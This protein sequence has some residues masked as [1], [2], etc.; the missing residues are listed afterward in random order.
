M[1]PLS[2]AQRRLWFIDRLE[3][4]SATYN[5]P[6]RIRFDGGLDVEALRSALN[7]VVARH[8]SLR[9]LVTLDD[10]GVPWQRVL[11]AEEAE[12]DLPVVEI[13]GGELDA[14]VAEA[15]R[16]VLDVEAGIP[17]RATLFRCGP[18]RHVLLLLIHHIASD[19]ESLAPLSRDLSTAYTA[20][21]RGAAPG[22]AELPVQYADYTLWQRELLGDEADP[23]SVFSTQS[24]YWQAELAGL[25]Q[26]I[27]LPLDRPRPASA[28]HRG[29]VISARLE[30]ELVAAIGALARE[31]GCTPPML[32]QAALAVL[33]QHLG[34]G[35]DVAVGSTIAG[36]TDDQLG[37]LIGFFVNSWVLRVDLSGSPS[38]G[39]VLARVKEKALGAYD[40]QDIPF[41]RL[42]ELVNPVR[43]TAWHP[44]FQVMFTWGD[45]LGLD[46]DLPS[47]AARIDALPTP[48]AKFDLEVNFFSDPDGHGL[49][50]AL[51]YAT[52]LFDRATAARVIE[53][54]LRVI[55]Q[56]IDAPDL[57]VAL[58]DPL[59]EQERAGLLEAARG[60]VSELPR[61]YVPAIVDEQARAHPD[62]VAVLCDGLSLTYAELCWRADRVASALARRGAG[63]EMLVGLALPR[64]ADLVVGL[65]GILKCGAAYLPV[66]P[67]YP[68][69]RLDAV[70]AEARPAAILADRSTASALPTTESPIVLI[71]EDIDFDGDESGAAGPAVRGA[72]P[73]NIAYVMYTSGS[74][75]K[76]KGVAITHAGVV[77]GV[78]ALA[79][80][81]G[82]ESRSSILAATSIG[83]DVSV[84]EIVTPLLAGGS[85]EIVRDGLVIGERGGWSGGVVSTVPSV[86]AGVLDGIA[87]ELKADT[88]VFA[89]EVLPMS[90]A[91]RVRAALPGV[92][93]INAYG[94]TESFYATAFQLPAELSDGASAPIG[95]P[96]ANMRCYVLGPGLQPVPAG[97]V[98]EL[99]VAGAVG[100]GY[101]GRSELTAARFVADPFG[102]PGARMYRTGDLVRS[103]RDGVLE[104]VGRDDAQVK[105]RGVRV[106]T[107]EV[108]AALAAFPG[109][110]QAV[111]VASGEGPG[112]RLVG[113]V[114]PN[115]AEQ[116]AGDVDSLG[117]LTVDLT[118]LLSA[119][120]L[121]R[122]VAGRLPE[123][124][125]PSAFVVLDRVPLMSNG[126]LDRAALPEPEFRGGEYRAPA[127]RTEEVLASLYAD[128]LG[129]ERAG[130]DDDFFA[131]GGDSIRSIQVVS[132]AKGVGVEITPRDVFDCRTPA[133]L[134]RRTADRGP[135][136]NASVLNELEGGGIGWMPLLPVARYVLDLGGDSDRFAMAMAVDLPADIDEDGLSAT[137]ASVFECHDA[138]RSRLVAD[139]LVVSAP[140][141]VPAAPLV[142][143]IGWDHG[144]GQDWHDLAAAELDAAARRL[145]PAAGTMAQFVWFAPS[146]AAGRLLIVVHH[147][148]VDGVSWRVLL[149]DLASAWQQVRDGAPPVLLPARTSMRRWAHAIA[150]EAVSERRAAELPMWREILDTED[151]VLGARR[152][153]PAE[154]T[155]STMAHRW[156][157]LS[158]RTTEAVLTTL[159]ARYRSGAHDGL[160]AALAMA[161]IRWRRARGTGGSAVLVR[162]EGHGREEGAIPGAD[163]SRT[164]GW[165]TTTYPVGLDLSGIDLGGAFAGSDP[166][167][168]VVKAVK[169][170]LVAVP[171]RGIGFGLL[172]YLNPGTA[173]VLRNCPVPQIAFNYLGRY[174]SADLPE[175][176][177][178]LGWSQAPG[179]AGL[180]P[181]PDPDMCAPAVLDLHALVEDT[182]DGP[183]L[184]IRIGYAKNIL[185]EDETREL[186]ELFEAALAGLARHADSPGAGGLTPSDLPLVS[187]GQDAIAAWE[188]RYPGLRDAWPLTPMQAGLLFHAELAGAGF[189]S[190][191]M[192]LVLH[193][194]GPV[195]P[196]RLRRAGQ[197]LL[198]RYPNLRVA[199]PADTGGNRVQVVQD[200]VELPWRH[201]DFA[202]VKRAE[203]QDRLDR[204]LAEDRARHFGL[205]EAPLLR[206]SLVTLGEGR[207]DLVFTAHHVLLDGW[208]VPLLMEDLLR[209]YAT[210]GDRSGLPATRSYRDF[211]EWLAVQDHAAAREAWSAE[212]AGL[213]EPTLLL[214]EPSGERPPSGIGQVEVQLGRHE[215]RALARLG[216]VSGLT[217]NTLVQGA[218][219]LVLSFLTGRR[220]V[221]FGAA[222]SG[223]PP[224]VPGIDGMVGLFVTTLPIRVDCDPASTLR[225]LLTSLQRRQSALL[226]HHHR[227]LQDIQ[228]ESGLTALF[229]TLVGFESYP[230]DTA[231]LSAAGAAAG[232]EITGASPFSGAHY[233]LAVMAFA[234][235]YLRIALQY[236]HH[237][238]DRDAAE[239][240]AARLGRALRHLLADLDTLV[241]A[242][243]LAEP[244]E[245]DVVLERFNRTDVA[246]VTQTIP[247][248]IAAL[249][250]TQPDSVAVVCGDTVLSYRDLDSRAARLA[251]VLA[252]RGVDREAVVG[253][254]L[255]RS[256]DL[257]VA[258]AALLRAGGAY[259]PIDPEYP[260]ERMAFMLRDTRPALV[261]TT[262]ELADRFGAVGGPVLVLDDPGTAAEVESASPSA[263]LPGHADQL[264]YVMY[265][266]GSSGVPKGIAVPHRAV[267]GLADD[268]RYRGGDHQ[269]VL[270]HS[271]Q[272]FDAST[273]DL[274]VALLGGGRVVVAPPGRL[275][276]AA[277]AGLLAEEEITGL[278]LPT[279]LFRVVAEE[280]P[281]CLAG[282]REV[283][284]GG[285][286][287]P[288]AAIARVLRSCP[289]ISVVNGYGPTETTTFA[290]CYPMRSPEEIGDPVPIGRPMDGMRA[291]VL[292]AALRPA[293]PG[294]TGDLYL[295]GNGLARGYA[296]RR[297]L[298]AE[299]FVA[300]PFGGP[301]GRMYRTGDRVAWTAE[302]E[303]DYR[304]RADEQV[305][306]RGF[307][308]EPG[309]VEAAM[310]TRRGVAEAVVSW[311]RD[312]GGERRLVGYVVPELDGTDS[313]GGADPVDEWR[314]LYND[315]YAGSNAAFGEDFKGWNSSYDG[316]PIA[317]P[318]MAE[319]RDA[320]VGAILGW[321]PRRILEIGVGT[322]LLLARLVSEVEEFWGTDIS[323]PVIDRLTRQVERAGY[324]DRVRLRAGAADE[325]GGL[326]AARFDTVVL[327]SVVQYFPDT[328]YLDRV[329]SDAMG[330]LAPGGRIVVGDVRS[331]ASL[332]L[333]HA[334]VRRARHPGEPAAAAR[335]SIE[336]AMLMEEELAL[337]PEWFHRWAA[338]HGAVADIR[339]KRGRAHNELT[340]HRYEVT[341]HRAPHE[342]VDLAEAPV[343]RW[344]RHVGRLS[345]AE[346]WTG[347]GPVRIAGIPN[348]RLSGEAAAAGRSAPGP[349]LDPEDAASWA[350][351][352]GLGVILAPSADPR[353]FDAIIGFGLAARGQVL[354]GAFVPAGRAARAWASSPARARRIGVLVG[355]LHE[356]LRDQ[357]PGYLVPEAVIAIARVPLTANNK[358][359]RT[360]LPAPDFAGQASGRG[361]RGPREQILCGLCAEVLG[362]DRIGIDDDFFALGG[363][364]LSAT[365]LISRIRTT[366][367][368]EVPIS[369]VFESPT[370]A[371]LSSR[372]APGAP[373]R[374][375]LRPAGRR[376]EPVPMSYA[377]RRM[378]FIDRFEGPSA[379]YNAPVP[380]RLTGE[381]D[382]AALRQALGDVVARHESL[383]T[384][385]AEDADGIAC[386][387]VLPADEA[388]VGLPVSDVAADQVEAAVQACAA[389]EFDLAAEIPV[390]ASLLRCGPG[391][392]VLV[393]VFHHIAMDGSS[394]APF[395]RDLTEA[396]AAR[397][398]GRPPA[399]P[400]LPVQYADYTLWQQELLGDES[401]PDSV[402]A[403]QSAYWRDE[404]AGVPVPVPLPADRP[405]PPVAS[406]RGD[407]VQF[408]VDA[409]TMRA[410]EG[411]AREH[412]ATVAMVLQTA[413]AVLL[414]RLGGGEDLTI[415]SPIANRTDDQLADLVG[416]FVNTWVLRVAVS[417]DRTFAELLRVVRDRSLAAYENQDVPFERLVELLNP[418]RST[419]YQP[420]FQVMFA[421]Q[422][423]A[424]EDFALPGLD[425][426]FEPARTGTAKFDLYFNLADVPGRGVLGVLE[427]A[428]DLFDAPTARR[429]AGCF[430]RVLA[431]LVAEPDGRLGDV[432]LL[433]PADRQRMLTEFAGVAAPVPES[434]VPRLVEQTAA[435]S[436]DAVALRCGDTKL[437]YRE[438]NGQADRLAAELAVRGVGPERVVGVALPRSA[439]LVIALLAVWKAGGAYLPID[440]RYPSARLGLVIEA[441]Q[442]ASIL[443]DSSTEEMLASGGCPLLNVDR[444]PAPGTPVVRPA[445]NLRP[446]NA[447]YV[448]YTSG[449]TGTPKGV[450]VTHRGVVNGLSRLIEILEVGPGSTVLASTSVGFDVSVLEIFATLLSGGTVDLVRDA[451]AVAERGGWTGSVLC[452]VPSVFA[453]LLDQLPGKIDA[454]MIVFAGEA[455]P[456]ALVRRT[457]D[458]IP[459]VRVVNTYG[460]TESFYASAVPVAA[461]PGTGSVR[462]GRPLGNMR[463]YVLGEGLNPVPVGV[464]GELYVGGDI[465]RGYHN[466]A[467]LTAS[468]FV[469]DPFGEPGTRM[470]RTGDLVRWDHNGVLA[471]AGRADAQLK[472]R[473]IRIEPGE[474]EA[475]LAAHHG[476][477]R[478]AVAVHD[479][480][481]AGARLVGYVVPAGGSGGGSE[482]DLTAGVS[483]DEL[484]QF[485]AARLPE[486]MV[487]SLIEILGEFPLG[488]T[489]KLD[490][491][492]L[493]EPVWKAGEYSGPESPDEEILAAVYAEVLG[494]DRVGVGDDFFAVGGDSIRSIQV[495][496]RAAA[497]GV[498]I[499]PR[500]VFEHRCVARL[501]QAAA[502]RRG[503]ETAPVLAELPGGPIGRFPLPPAARYLTGLGG[504]FD[505][506][507]MSIVLDLPD[508]VTETELAATLR[509]VLDRHDVL[510]SRLDG[511][512]MVIEEPGRPAAVRRVRCAVSWESPAW[513]DLVAAE[514]D[515]ATGELDPAAGEMARFVWF[516]R[517]DRPGR[518]LLVLH[519]LV[520]DGVSWRILVPDLAAAW[521][522]VRAGQPPALGRVRTSMRRWAHALADE[523]AAARRV[524]ELPLW[525][526]IADG[527]DPLL[528]TRALD[529]A[530]DTMSTVDSV[531]VEAGESVTEAVLTRLPAVFRGGVN[532][533]L[534]T[535]LALA[536]ARWRAERGGAEPSVLLRLEGHGREEQ[537]VPGAD[538]SRTV[539]WFTSMFPVRLDVSG[540]DLVDAFAGGPAAGA[541]VKAV[542]EQL[543]S[544]PDKGIGYGLLRYLNPRTAGELSRLPSGQIGFNYLGRLAADSAPGSAG[545]SVA[546][547]T[548]GLIADFDADLPAL[549]GLEISAYAAETAAGPRLSARFAFPRGLLDQS[550]ARE[551]AR[552]WSAALEGLARHVSEPGAGGLTPSDLPLVSVSQQQ[553]DGLALRYPGLSDVWPLTST[554]SGLLFHSM[555][556]RSSFDA[557]HM[558]LV[559]HL[560]GPVDPARLRA[561][562]QSLLDR[563]PN[564]RTAFVDCPGAGW[565][566]LVLDDVELPWSEADLR[567]LPPAERQD[568]LEQFLA[569]D[570]ARHFE[571]AKAPLLRMSLLRMETEQ[572]ELVFTANHVLY[573][574]WSL[575]LLMR[576]LLRLYEVG[577]DSAALPPARSYRDFLVWLADRSD[578]EAARQWAAELEGVTEPTML[579]NDAEQGGLGEI[580]VLLAPGEAQNLARRAAELAVTVNTV[581]QAAWAIVLSALTGRDDVLF[582]ATVS[583]R[584]PAVDGVESMAGLFVNTI[585]VRVR[586]AGSD[587]VAS[588][589]ADLQQRQAALLEH[590]HYGL[591]DIQRA[592]G[593][594]P[595]FDT[596]VLF[597]SY[598][599][600]RAALGE[601]SS[602]AGIRVAGIRPL[603]GTHYP[604]VV[605][606]A[607]DPMLRVG[608]QYQ[609]TA[610]SGSAAA[611]IAEM[612]RLVL[613][614]LAETPC[615]PVSAVRVTGREECDR[616]LLSGTGTETMPGPLLPDLFA[617][618]A[619]ATPDAVAVVCGDSVLTYR[620]LDLR[621]NRLAQWLIRL[622]AGPERRVVVS[623]PR[624][625][626]LV[627][628]LLAVLKAGAS[629]VPV[630]PGHPPARTAVIMRDCDPV[631]VLD[632]DS[633]PAGLDDCPD[634]APAVAVAPASTA[635]VAYTSG[636]T[637][638]P[639][640]VVIPHLALANLLGALGSEFGLQPSDRLLAVTTVA[641]DIAAL[642]IYLPLLAGAA[643]VIAPAESAAEPAELARLLRH[644]DVTVM[645]ATPSLWQMLAA[646]DRTAFSGIR[647]FVGGEAVPLSLADE[648]RAAASDVT[649]LYGPTETT[650]WSVRARL[651]GGPPPI[652][653]P[654]ANTRAYVL[655]RFLHPAPAGVTGELYLAGAGLARGYFGAP[656]LSATRFVADPFAEGERMYRT[657]DLVRWREPGVL[658]Y[659][660]RADFQLKVR[661][662]RIEPGEVETVLAAHDGVSQA[663]V[664]AREDQPGGPRLVAYV[665]PSSGIS[666]A[667]DET[668]RQIEEWR[669]VY[670][671]AYVAPGSV[672]A[673][674]GE[675]FA[676]WTSAVTGE[677][678]PL[679]EMSAWRDAAVEQVLR[680]APRRVLEVGVGPGLLLSRIADHVEEFWGT[681]VSGEVIGRL[682]RQCADREFAGR[683]RLFAGA[684]HETDGLPAG[685]FD[686]VVLNSVVQYFPNADYLN[687]VLGRLSTLLCPAGRLVIGDV[688]DADSLSALYDEVCLARHP[689][690]T[691]AFRRAATGQAA[692]TERELAVAPGWFDR[693]ARE[694]GMAADIRLKPGRARN[695]LTR[696]RYEVVLSAA[697][698][699]V[700][701]LTGIPAEPWRGWERAGEWCRTHLED[702]PVRISALP[703]ARF[704][705]GIDPEDAREWAAGHGW[706]ALASPSSAGPDRFDLVV[707][708]DHP[709]AV[710]GTFVASGGGRAAVT[711]PGRARGIGVLTSALRGYARERL[712]EYMV[713]SA[714]VALAEL[715]LTPNGKTDRRALP[716]PDGIGNVAGRRPE[717]PCQQ[718]LAGLF[719]EVL[720][721]PGVDID[722]DFFALG[723]H[724]LL[725]AHLVTRVREA[726]GADLPIRAVFQW[727]TVA[728]LS[729][730]LS[731]SSGTDEHADPFGVVLPI[732]PAGEREPLWFIHPGIGLSWAYLGFAHHL[733]ENWPLYGIQAR[734]FDGSRVP[735]SVGEMVDDYLEQILRVQPE[736]PYRLVGLSLGG[737]LAHAM[738]AELQRRGRRV[739]TLA[740]LDCVPAEWFRENELPEQAEAQSFF[741]TH[742]PALPGLQHVEG[743]SLA[744]RASEIML[745]HLR[746]MRDFASPVF[747]GDVLFFSAAEGSAECYADRW[748]GHVSG[749]VR[750]HEIRC[751]HTELHLPGPAAA[752]CRVLSGALEGK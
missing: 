349:D 337:D 159:P 533:G 117:D 193:L 286:V 270:V 67:R 610:F 514:L 519:H 418:E 465:A 222:A 748:R 18:E 539:G 126:K 538:L 290:T 16:Q 88:V 103:G 97:V 607:A 246:P 185:G 346:R 654:I 606:A 335:A 155:A 540:I 41:E 608:L 144:W 89:G 205:D 181:E 671:H 260:P 517:E 72:R 525:Q 176:L 322:G 254:A 161:V 451:L 708:P 462:L 59:T 166:A 439:G 482:V 372:L 745:E 93:V 657:G 428:T 258:L 214:P 318:E 578:A 592:A 366:F 204:L 467:Q 720:G 241:G 61:K 651:A 127:N 702:R 128:V 35:S 85:V 625:A 58:A 188:R 78:R 179:T 424:R 664:T 515:A 631:A 284:T 256:A 223:R 676:M 268:H 24:R 518:L 303:L 684:A 717:N 497:L 528:G 635:Y 456:D 563:Y 426:R 350:A 395:A 655:D 604:M 689:G 212:L 206:L 722:A 668:A 691:D 27:R 170:Q 593:L 534:L 577:G 741:A 483:R 639:K 750:Q 554:Q 622:G 315:L 526:A 321:E 504:G 738:A 8:E 746:K 291:Y 388:A 306:V 2:S 731:A 413:V 408:A 384:V 162:L 747:D 357:L 472:I 113:Y 591:A 547:D 142:R 48:T 53:R 201:F 49:L 624:S 471:Y 248:R 261:V 361:P 80:A 51:Q 289:G 191:Q 38:F 194:A 464:V 276:T 667:P 616:L 457:A 679:S 141:S 386:Q 1:I 682:R 444:L 324:A 153:D 662:F 688:R 725:A 706:T 453:G 233:P 83:F 23:D 320:A 345:E 81:M 544:V 729:E 658:D 309:E 609:E 523:A 218:W 75:G 545:W 199:F 476:V 512:S 202:G 44:L 553:I 192:Q 112:R 100:R 123:F 173:E 508:G 198:D 301:G 425:V 459:G 363:H 378:W 115:G 630:D 329:L 110:R 252:R 494:M 430:V 640:G 449:S 138:L 683:V 628:A 510:R 267:L 364:S 529:S 104:Y 570:H 165:F 28:S 627:V 240:I 209:L 551:L 375:P 139:G 122:F 154:D 550:E 282:V 401:D 704:G 660:G 36:R 446:G 701:S 583:G 466:A 744:D 693:W 71:D 369:A 567:P 522:A 407:L 341:L 64:T 145:D 381:L 394:M 136:G 19:G 621:S 220:D 392:Y 511:D 90:L 330:L 4:P 536:V 231:A 555:L 351:S 588:V 213:D 416:F 603:S 500:D 52:D 380:L 302:G 698:A 22:W 473:G 450:T 211:L 730:R 266:S 669:E 273:Y 600:D 323:A 326:P 614:Q 431:G 11:P 575:P 448:M 221:V 200:R 348:A 634:T 210:G 96:L 344:G 440:P 244:A 17:V 243:D 281:E 25:P 84:F 385:F 230:I 311:T 576:D 242:T 39:E 250:R 477:A 228:R 434:V 568:A 353:C 160:L 314:Q 356:H 259:L 581:V 516:D 34:A 236:Q 396:Y 491:S 506:F 137:L 501:A 109:V 26:P 157:H 687:D 20:R 643:V 294:V 733:D 618:Q 10:D 633:L 644:H 371:E 62:R 686:V 174:S 274:W 527:P 509:A 605:V 670:D 31:H 65:L 546:A 734:G 751:R 580:E 653:G 584:P 216:A 423:Y 721:L 317:A 587:T 415:G 549:S 647:C 29:D 360:A 352:Q 535:A 74:T 57:S 557:Y 632:S 443:V 362:L 229:D 590:H 99:Y 391:E 177:R 175:S 338:G 711:D 367:G 172:R 739:A 219:A 365:R 566:Q 354:A 685:H 203:Q 87:S 442:P 60:A 531:A 234:E 368:V 412:E 480:G 207:S 235:P 150:D 638:A 432:E 749:V 542:K 300:C 436:P 666:S 716:S 264:A 617:G 68:S 340:R 589:L 724:S 76:P 406:H 56:L 461:E 105:V 184:A 740:L 438:L 278:C 101:H 272:A 331:V 697:G 629:Y 718:V 556:A 447:A 694:H 245:R 752:M 54:Y 532:D 503:S 168:D 398:A 108:E 339:L 411:L 121:R 134:A 726:L 255:P 164:V 537:I 400:D 152:L 263:P 151:P 435:G 559:F 63:P 493:P 15:A 641:F 295:A 310:R 663:V 73:D 114:V 195:L 9:T 12:A 445:A 208:S 521:Q 574:G 66:D 637:G 599:V 474:V 383:R 582:G 705:D 613:A 50:C 251:T 468:R 715:P 488:P 189:D 735:G 507:S 135:A 492:A 420:L 674:W 232:I 710:S 636:S 312:S 355:E 490:R 47:L 429:I 333:F 293:L 673:E 393:L 120:D 714:V 91:R 46:L 489:G 279:G 215:G 21:A 129:L 257:V 390:R 146:Q 677:P 498:E 298:T 292:D 713:P 197:A 167:G 196:E 723:G 125:V 178:G 45:D 427:Y 332:E 328:G 736:G 296:Q 649:N 719:A 106:E 156:L 485:A 452:T 646:Y 690:A 180:I 239:A 190:Y 692:L 30:P 6:F 675:D 40:N 316:T 681:D 325:I 334:A 376:P 594:G 287:V 158:A 297:G 148:A 560:E 742:L 308:V 598:P 37:D 280:H 727:P 79:D 107:G 70:L 595:L 470:Y 486:F 495:V 275:D 520:V 299:R 419:A 524:D 611:G 133:E 414:M 387:R 283:W 249:V 359:D 227:G 7:D 382:V 42:V 458:A 661:G 672:Q 620:E 561:A 409:R 217:V 226:G 77:N 313:P 700:R 225:D 699:P 597:E 558:Q 336:R 441:A 496:A 82:I 513:R 358:V 463:A 377:Q 124:M 478:A 469:A 562:G 481:A 421:W 648:L 454:D 262:A 586:L 271:P 149:P 111:V 728:G 433:T 147:L 277:L 455:L 285:D 143:T 269:R 484:R 565:L 116:G 32:L 265:T 585:P 642:E 422:N 169:E 130:A 645:Q 399:F 665:V 712:P 119:R 680:S 656:A 14:A 404:L 186:A 102:P 132:R 182:D 410:V 619:D 327:N 460:Q 118:A 678:I 487:P 564:L 601:A 370:V 237:R 92:R 695:E 95:S 140:G 475:V 417:P 402:L 374:P 479:A 548:L 571:P 626:D 98:G 579:A 253:V 55:R 33:L 379:V 543:L 502:A 373:L 437:T 389:R 732:R 499:T 530:V 615:Q 3:G 405:R 187:A 319:W 737:T 709:V 397:R 652:G 403:T 342:P 94:Q 238:L 43:S 623:L 552:W 86:F 69:A 5:V 304:G 707:L 572:S 696:H 612:L 541:A 596:I 602:A 659:V 224:D 307:R 305:K 573:D 347:D 743:T 13:T 703:N 131:L 183:V 650:I 343:L 288:P 569:Q 505:R 163:L 247:D 171:D